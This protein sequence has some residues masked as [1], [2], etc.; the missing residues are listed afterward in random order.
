MRQP[1][2]TAKSHDTHFF[3]H[4]AS[5]ISGYACWTSETM[6][7]PPPRRGMDDE[8]LLEILSTMFESVSLEHAGWVHMLCAQESRTEMRDSLLFAA[9]RVAVRPSEFRHEPSWENTMLATVDWQSEDM[10]SAL[11]MGS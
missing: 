4:N 3:R 10:L 5:R 8:Q 9:R 1:T 2:V 11:A 7:E 6:D